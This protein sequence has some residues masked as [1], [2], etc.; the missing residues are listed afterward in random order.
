MNKNKGIIGIG[1]ILAIVLGIVVVGS[2][3]Y[4]LGKSGTK[5]GIN[6]QANVIPNVENQNLPVDNN[7]QVNFPTPIIP[8][9]STGCAANSTPSITVLSPNGGET[10]TAGQK[11]TVKWES[12]NLA[13]DINSVF[14]GITSEFDKSKGPISLVGQTENDGIEI[15]TLPNELKGWTSAGPGKFYKVGIS[16][17]YKAGPGHTY[18]DD[19]D[20]TFT[21]NS[22][23]NTFNLS[24]FSSKY[25]TPTNWPPT[26]QQNATVYSCSTISR[27]VF[28]T[29]TTL[30]GTQKNINGKTFCLYSFSDGGAGHYAGVYT[31]IT[32]GLNGS[33]TKRVDFRV[34]W[35]NCGVYGTT[36]DSQY[37][38]CTND[39][40]KFFN[41]LDAYI[42]SLM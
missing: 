33:G 31:Y 5:Q 22:G 16:Y 41:N 12:C 32:A 36:G 13:K 37:D 9:V 14:I 8:A 28:D 27:D 42:A 34:D 19:S 29:P 10:Y 21:I 3:A 11:I 15:V 38:Q 40:S 7:Q 17:Q 25:I 30:T 20:N 4:Y 39:Q 6:N 24:T 2:G 23:T 35:G 18:F 26:V 1:L